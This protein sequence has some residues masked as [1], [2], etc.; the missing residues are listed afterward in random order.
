MEPERGKRRRI[1]AGAGPGNSQPLIRLLDCAGN[2]MIAPADTWRMHMTESGA[3]AWRK[4][5]SPRVM[6]AGKWAVGILG[7]I[8]IIGFLVLPPA[9]RHFGER[10]LADA[11]GRQ[12]TIEGVRINPF[13]LSLT[14]NNLRIAEADGTLKWMPAGAA[15]CIRQFPRCQSANDGVRPVLLLTL[16]AMCQSLRSEQVPVIRG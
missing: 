14:V 9:V 10:A 2:G 12:V 11:L 7:A 4:M 6:R 16:P 15:A 5:G 8:A 1:R 3:R 13:A